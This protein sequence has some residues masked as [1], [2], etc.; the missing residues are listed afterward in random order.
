M[1]ASPPNPA[2]VPASIAAFRRDR[3]GDLLQRCR[4][5]S[6]MLDTLRAEGDYPTQYRL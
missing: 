1:S 6:A 3:S 4:E 2:A 5:F